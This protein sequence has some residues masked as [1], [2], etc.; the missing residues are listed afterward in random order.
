MRKFSGYTLIE[1]LISIFF[2]AFC[3]LFIISIFPTASTATKQAENLQIASSIAHQEMEVINNTYFSSISNFSGSY[4]YSGYRN[5]VNHTQNYIYNVTVSN[6]SSTLKDVVINITWAE[7][8]KPNQ[9]LNIETLI[10]N[11]SQL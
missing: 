10:Y 9:S 5:G 8:K 6:I 1:T 7:L 2:L 4:L 3:I 11:R